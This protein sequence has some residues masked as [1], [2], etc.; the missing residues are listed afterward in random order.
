[1]DNNRVLKSLRYILDVSDKDMQ[2]IFALGRSQLDLSQVS[3]MLKAEDHKDF[4]ALSDTD[5][6]H[7]L[8]GLILQKRGPSDHPPN[9]ETHISN[10]LVLRKIRIAFDL[11]EEDMIQTIGR[12]GFVIKKAELSALFRKKGHKHYRVCGDQILRYFLKGLA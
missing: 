3:D 5:L 7:F 9:C 6:I 11:K 8:D 4:Q 2:E 10:N 1:M 12:G